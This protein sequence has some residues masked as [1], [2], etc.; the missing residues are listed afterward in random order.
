MVWGFWPHQDSVLGTIPLIS[1]QVYSLGNILHI[2]VYY[3]YMFVDIVIWQTM[4][5]IKFQMS[6]TSTSTISRA[7]VSVPTPFKGQG[8]ITGENIYVSP[9]SRSLNLI[10]FLVKLL[11]TGYHNVP[12]F[13][14]WSILEGTRKL[15]WSNFFSRKPQLSSQGGSGSSLLRCWSRLLLCRLQPSLQGWETHR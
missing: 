13:W 3:I 15:F 6:K 12:E 4:I 2:Y 11:F 1:L 9:L 14:C 8:T 7:F 10:A 5:M